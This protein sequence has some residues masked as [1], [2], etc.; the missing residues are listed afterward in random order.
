MLQ[1]MCEKVVEEVHKYIYAQLIDYM[2]FQLS[3]NFCFYLSNFYVMAL[4]M[5]ESMWN[6]NENEF[7]K[8]KMKG[9]C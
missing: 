6:L 5:L 7:V 1:Q 8:K 9:H 4:T 3:T 2:N